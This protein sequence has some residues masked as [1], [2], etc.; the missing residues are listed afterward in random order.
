[1]SSKHLRRLLEDREKDT[2]SK[3]D[4]EEEVEDV[5]QEPPRLNRFAL[6]CDDD[7]EESES[8]EEESEEEQSETSSKKT[9]NVTSKDKSV[10]KKKNKKKKKGKQKKASTSHKQDYYENDMLTV[11]EVGPDHRSSVFPVVTVKEL[12]KVDPKLFDPTAELKKA[13]GKAFKENANVG[14]S[15][16]NNKSSG[17]IVKYKNSWPPMRSTGLS[18]S[19]EK[20]E[21][22]VTW[23]KFEHSPRY[24]GYEIS[25]SNAEDRMD[26]EMIHNV[27]REG[28]YHLNSLLLFANST[29]MQ[30][31]VTI[32]A[33]II[34]QGVYFAEQSLHSQCRIT[35]W[36]H[37]LN[38]RIYENRAFY[39][40]LH[41]FMLNCVDKRCFETALNI[42]KLIF[43]MDPQGDPLAVILSIDSIALKCRRH[44][45]LESVLE[46]CA[47]WKRLDLLPNFLY[48]QAL[49][50]FL[51][52]VTEEDKI[53][54]DTLLQKALCC[55]PGVVASLVEELQI[56]TDEVV[57][58]NKYFNLY[59]F[60]KEREGLQLVIKIYVKQAG[61][62]WKAPDVLEW[63]ER[64]T[65][66]VI[67]DE[68][69]QA[70]LEDWIIKRNALYIGMPQNIKRLAILLGIL[71]SDRAITDPEPPVEGISSY[72]KM[73]KSP[74]KEGLLQSFFS[75]LFPGGFQQG[76]ALA[77]TVRDLFRNLSLNNGDGG[78][79][80]PID[81]LN[82]DQTD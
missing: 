2:G 24:Q 33:D 12:F 4:E 1:M 39:L 3:S 30:E 61:E 34:E 72:P 47:G 56:E 42:A 49:I 6:M 59:A 29:R 51:D 23:F 15:H 52:A 55:F 20:V 64:N 74:N 54:A 71:S 50:H 36:E 70:V 40:L 65:K 58:S 81:R 53:K 8:E 18:M 79:N 38:Y 75:S 7:E 16:R 25:V 46:T 35:S 62:L 27:L 17:R 57:S 41:R 31:D 77:E 66:F 32:S 68:K 48:S 19:I 37:R 44:S 69:S 9:P 80:I 28:Y 14:N 21:G 26:L 82:I 76:G 43:T 73:H 67:D 78:D 11:E 60:N 45:W 5:P 13:L 22:D 63:L 10:G